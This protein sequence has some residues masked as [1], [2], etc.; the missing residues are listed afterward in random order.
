MSRR[1]ESSV[2]SLSL[3]CKIL[4]WYRILFHFISGFPAEVKIIDSSMAH[5]V[6]SVGAA[7]SMDTIGVPLSAQSTD[8]RTVAEAPGIIT[9]VSPEIAGRED[10]LG[11]SFKQRGEKYDSEPK[12]SFTPDW[13]SPP[14]NDVDSYPAMDRVIPFL[15]QESVKT[16]PLGPIY[17]V[18]ENCL[19]PTQDYE[20]MRLEINKILLSQEDP[21]SQSPNQFH[22]LP[23]MYCTIF[24]Y[25]FRQITLG[26]HSAVFVYKLYS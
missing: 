10:L 18:E 13:Q 19:L 9:V 8:T 7:V 16:S 24:L 5:Q 2:A 14:Y 12:K 26:L 17:N 11:K 1:W 20:E 6:S 23:V 22:S 4:F 3:K 25:L 21:A 15:S